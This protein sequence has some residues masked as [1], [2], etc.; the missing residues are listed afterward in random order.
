MTLNLLMDA[1]TQALKAGDAPSKSSKG[2][3][4]PKILPKGRGRDVT[5]STSGPSGSNKPGN[6]AS[7]TNTP[8]PVAHGGKNESFSRPTGST[9]ITE[10]ALCPVN[11]SENVA[12]SSSNSM[13]CYIAQIKKQ[14]SALTKLVSESRAEPI[15]TATS[16]KNTATS[17]RVA[18]SQPSTSSH[19]NTGSVTVDALINDIDNI[20]D[21]DNVQ[22]SEPD[23]SESLLLSISQDLNIE[24][25]V[26]PKIS[27]GI[28]NLVNSMG[29]VD[30]D[31]SNE[32]L[33]RYV[34]P[35]NCPGLMQVKVNQLI[36]EKMRRETQ[37]LDVKFQKCQALLNAATV[38]M[39]ETSNVIYAATKN[40][41]I[42]NKNANW[43]AASIFKKD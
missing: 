25:K 2:K 32:K 10:S 29:K 8:P 9:G 16:S 15:S 12:A 28:A 35:E 4:T 7:S 13:T 19:S 3:T 41:L 38:A 37:T 42:P 27:E 43:N 26:G 36:W 17:G 30:D 14:I 40:K 39:V 33:K 21:D 22:D 31:T 6:S 20:M 5:S 11:N 23:F 1:F 18:D 24:D 34:R